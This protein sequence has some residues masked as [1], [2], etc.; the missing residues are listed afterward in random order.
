MIKKQW[1][2]IVVALVFLLVVALVFI[3]FLEFHEN[4]VEQEGWLFEDPIFPFV[5]IFDVSLPIFSITYGSVLLYFFLSY[6]QSHFLARL[7]MA[8]GFIVLFRM[9]TMSLVPLKE[10]DTLVYLEDPFLNNLIY[11]GRIVTDLFFSGHTALI[12]AIFILSGKRF[13]FLALTILMGLLVMIQ[14]VH[15]SID[16]LAAIPFAWLAAYFTQYIFARWANE[17]NE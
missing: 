12:F 13:V 6:K 7:M 11:P 17:N 5:P 8:Y 9:I 10:P 15:Y 14:R 4:R 3:R 1:K 2:T 16:V